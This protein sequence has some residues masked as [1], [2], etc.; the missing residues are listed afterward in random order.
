[1]R[2]YLP[3]AGAE[4]R[5]PEL[6]APVV[7]QRPKQRVGTVL[8]VDDEVSLVEI[9]VNF[10]GKLGYTA[11][12]ACDGPEALRVLA[13]TAEIDVI[14][15]DVI[16][17]GGMDGMELAQQVHA[18]RPEI[19]VVYSTGF[20]SEALSERRRPLENSRVLQK[21]YRLAE[22]AEVVERAVSDT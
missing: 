5:Q 1:V 6:A 13:E 21:P 14:V 19:R 11:L 12:S 2:M 18:L 7:A 17:G 9:A 16:M 3:T 15:T 8:I 20:P 22:L 10:L 4:E